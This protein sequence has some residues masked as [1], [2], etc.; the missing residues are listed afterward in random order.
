MSRV[1]F[2]SFFL[3]LCLSSCDNKSFDTKNKSGEGFLPIDTLRF[4]RDSTTFNFSNF[5]KLSNEFEDS[6]ILGN[7][8][9]RALIFY[10]ENAKISKKVPLEVGGPQ[11]ILGPVSGIYA[12]NPDTI[13]VFSLGKVFMMNESGK[14]FDTRFVLRFDKQINYYVT[15]S[16]PAKIVDNKLYYAPLHFGYYRDT[17][18]SWSTDLADKNAKPQFTGYYPEDMKDGVWIGHPHLEN[19]NTFHTKKGTFIYG[20]PG[21]PYLREYDYKGEEVKHWAAPEDFGEL[22]PMFA[23]ENDT[24]ANGK[25]VGLRAFSKYIFSFV[26]YD[27]YKDLIYRAYYHPIGKPKIES[28]SANNYRQELDF[29]ILAIDANTYEIIAESPRY[30]GKDFNLTN[31]FVNENGL[32]IQFKDVLEDEAAFLCFDINKN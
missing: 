10:D 19:Y 23:D 30:K 24:K 26:A 1:V 7:T 18:V 15:S 6:Y 9:G 27:P 29:S 13:C 21:D 8:E 2:I 31:Q 25:Q 32:H 14:I 22:T 17:G 20:I 5:Y 12:H 11:G 28:I 4:E 16:L 3:S